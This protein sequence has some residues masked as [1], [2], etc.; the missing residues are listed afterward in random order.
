MISVNK[1]GADWKLVKAW[2]RT[3][4]NKAHDAMEA[5]QSIEEYH[6]LRG[7]ILLARALID[8]VEPATPPITTEDNYGISSPE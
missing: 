3:S 8:E 7:Q 4:I 6:F 2:L 5:G 1:E